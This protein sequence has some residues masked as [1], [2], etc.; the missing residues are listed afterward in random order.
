MLQQASPRF[1]FQLLGF[2]PWL[3]L[4]ALSTVSLSPTAL[5]AALSATL[6]APTLPAF[7]SAFASLTALLALL[8]RVGLRIG[9]GDHLP[10]GRGWAHL[11]LGEVLIGFLS[12][13]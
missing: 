1:V 6:S 7:A 11:V 4:T 5:S 2:W 8:S 13:T 9:F 10:T 3:V 12:R